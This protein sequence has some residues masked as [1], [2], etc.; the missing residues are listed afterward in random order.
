MTK[1]ISYFRI[2]S[3]LYVLDTPG[4]HLPGDDANTDMDTLMKL[5]MCGMI[6][7]QIVGHYHVADYILYRLNLH[8]NYLYLKYCNKQY[9]NQP[10]DDIDAVLN[11]MAHH[12]HYCNATK[13]L[14]KEFDP[15]KGKRVETYDEYLTA[16]HLIDLYRNGKLDHCLLDAL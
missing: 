3:D 5:S 12:R 6:A 7:D 13:Y 2:S 11:A 8:R 4:I 9:V 1:H 14:R 16:L 15:E 10:C